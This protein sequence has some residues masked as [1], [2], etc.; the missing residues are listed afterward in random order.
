MALQTDLPAMMAELEVESLEGYVVPGH[1][2]LM[3]RALRRVGRVETTGHGRMND[4][5]MDWVVVRAA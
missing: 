3:T 2:R 1:S 4:H 5:A